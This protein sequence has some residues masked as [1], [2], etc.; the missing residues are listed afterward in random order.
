MK[1]IT[2]ETIGFYKAMGAELTNSPIK[3]I[4]DDEPDDLQMVYYV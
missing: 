4:A 1:K 2:E 3:E